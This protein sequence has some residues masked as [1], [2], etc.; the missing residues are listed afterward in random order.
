MAID[1]LDRDPSST[2]A[3]H[4][5]HTHIRTRAHTHRLV[6][7]EDRFTYFRGMIEMLYAKVERKQTNFFKV[8]ACPACPALAPPR[9]DTSLSPYLRLE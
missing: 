3:L 4:K 8:C 1:A 9:H 6:A 5:Q 2:H 7:P